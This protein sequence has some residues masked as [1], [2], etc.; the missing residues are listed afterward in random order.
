MP[1]PVPPPDLAAVTAAF[2]GAG[3]RFVVIGGFAVIANRHVRATRDVDLL[4]PDDPLNDAACVVA[5]DGL[6]AVRTRDDRPVDVSMLE[7]SAHLRAVGRGGLIDLVR[8]GA[9]PLDYATVASRA[10][11]ADLGVDI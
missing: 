10:L 6:D 2:L 5:L 4:I 9:P 3:A 8:E 11:R 7:G 1:Q